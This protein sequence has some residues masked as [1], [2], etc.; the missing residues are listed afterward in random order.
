MK[1]EQ[2]RISLRDRGNSFDLMVEAISAHCAQKKSL[3][4][5]YQFVIIDFL[6]LG[7]QL[8]RFNFGSPEISLI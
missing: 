7:S 1:N 5:D 8:N 2:H 4:V 6:V 3:K